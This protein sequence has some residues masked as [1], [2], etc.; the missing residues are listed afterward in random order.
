MASRRIYVI[1]SLRNPEVPR[2]AE[3]LR[4][5]GHQ[6]HDDWHAPGPETDDFWR[7]YEKARGRTFVEA[8]KGRHAETVFEYDKR[9][10][11]WAD[12]VVMLM[13]AGKSGHLEF[14]WAI[15]QGKEGHILLEPKEDR[16]DVMYKF[17]TEVWDDPDTFFDYMSALEG[18]DE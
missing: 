16:W 6:V 12:T 14:G 18:M 2:L 3:R 11:T 5:L 10:L 9:W 8:L 17:A 1:G 4:A 7:A 13:P 15:G